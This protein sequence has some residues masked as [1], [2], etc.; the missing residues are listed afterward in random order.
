MGNSSKKL[1]VESVN[2]NTLSKQVVESIIQLLISGPRA[3][4][5]I[6]MVKQIKNFTKSLP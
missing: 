5:T 6:I 2:R 4:K 1:T 3:A